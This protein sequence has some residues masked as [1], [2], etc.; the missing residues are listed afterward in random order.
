MTRAHTTIHDLDNLRPSTSLNRRQLFSATFELTDIFLEGQALPAPQPENL[1]SLAFSTDSIAGLQLS[2][3]STDR[4]KTISS[5]NNTQDVLLTPHVDELS[6]QKSRDTLV[7]GNLAYFQL[8]ASPGLFWIR[9]DRH[10]Q[11]PT[12]KFSIAAY[13][14]D[15]NADQYL[16]AV[17]VA[18]NSLIGIPHRLRVIRI[19]DDPAVME[20]AGEGHVFSRKHKPDWT[21][22]DTVKSI[23][24]VGQHSRSSLKPY[25]CTETIH[26]FSLASG[27]MYERL[28]RIMILSVRKHTQ[29]PLEFWFID[30]FLSPKFKLMMPAMAER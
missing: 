28:L 5:G 4:N 26:I 10:T 1:T 18:V 22:W 27:H 2:I 16:T 9:I 3:H 6:Q 11:L 30:N 29:C 7:M 23:V 19:S 14:D 15:Y 13:D 25:D 20:V 8:R 21:L 24:T 17:P 12:S